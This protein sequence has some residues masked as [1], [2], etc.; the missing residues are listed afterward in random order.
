MKRYFALIFAGLIVPGALAAQT[1]SS[2]P[3]VNPSNDNTRY[4]G[5]TAQFL[6]L[7]ADARG[8]ALGGS[9]A[10]LVSD[11]SS[12]FWNPAGLALGTGSQ[13]G[14]T[15]DRYVADTRHVW[16][17]LS[18]PVRGG[19][20][21][22]GVNLS[23]FG[24][25]DQPIYTEDQQDGTGDN[26]SV[27]ETAVGLSLALQFSDRFSA[28]VT[29]KLIA[30]QL[31]GVSG[32]GFAVDLGTNYH[33]RI[34]GRPVRAS[35]IM[36]NYGSSIALS[37]APLNVTIPPQGG[38][39]N[40]DPQP[41]KY[42]TSTWEPPTMF[43]VG[44]AYD[45]LASTSSRLTLLSEFSQPTDSDPGY[46]LA[47]EYSIGLQAVTAQLR[48]SYSY[49]GDNSGT[50][51]TAAGFTSAQQ[52]DNRLDGLALGGGLAWKSGN[53]GVGL[54]YAY[55]NMGILPAVNMFTVKVGF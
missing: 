47:A 9:Y 49:Q 10:A 25:S 37:G 39:Q 29:G 20:W 33:S 8:A 51:P 4:G 18:T 30:E 34:M 14:F 22:V 13:A 42:S 43:R 28:G 12:M 27:S 53:F 24:F 41:A 3:G 46:G 16:A 19:E 15:Y 35:F 52:D 5:T 38:T 21:A 6:S 54:D 45:V 23:S 32:T 7:P 1:T 17:G 44:V 48:G 11:V 36:T 50:N 31:A 2:G 40:V 55:R 26:Y